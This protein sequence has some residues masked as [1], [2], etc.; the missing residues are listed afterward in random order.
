M[1]MFENE[2]VLIR[3]Q[4]YAFVT[5]ALCELFHAVGMRNV[6]KSFVRKEFF[7]NKL[8]LFSVV[9]GIF[10]Q[11]LVTEVRLFN[12]LFRTVKIGFFGWC[13]VAGLSLIVLLVHEM[14]IMLGKFKIKCKNR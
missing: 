14:L 3:G 7:D 1:Y 6:N 9:F 5:L 10:V 8:M 13:Y 2:S 11:V 12:N 4:T